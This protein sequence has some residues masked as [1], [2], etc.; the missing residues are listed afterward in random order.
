MKCRICG[1]TDLNA[2]WDAL[3]DEPCHWAEEDL[4]SVCAR[5]VMT[6]KE[7]ATRRAAP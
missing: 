6:R 2:C 4:C 1:C 5:V 7:R 3:V